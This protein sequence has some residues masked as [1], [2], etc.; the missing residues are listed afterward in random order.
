MQRYPAQYASQHVLVMFSNTPYAVAFAHGRVQRAF[1]DQICEQATQLADVDWSR[2]DALMPEY[3]RKLTP[4]PPTSKPALKDER[5]GD[6][7][8]DSAS[9]H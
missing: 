9:L 1:L 4:L 5:L 2:V 7:C 3:E 6:D 8:E